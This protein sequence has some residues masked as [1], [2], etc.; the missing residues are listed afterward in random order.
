MDP[1]DTVKAVESIL[2]Q[3]DLKHNLLKNSVGLLFC[4]VDF[5]TSGMVKELSSRL[6]FEVVGCTSLGFSVPGAAEEI[7]FILMVLTSDDVEFSTGISEP[8][9]QNAEERIAELYRR[10]AGERTAKPALVFTFPPLIHNLSGNTVVD[11]LDRVSGGSPIIGGVAEDAGVAI[12]SPQTIY[13]GS[14][15]PDRLP[16]LL[17]FGDVKVRFLLDFLPGEM[18]FNQQAVITKAEGNRLI[19][20]DN[21]PAAAFM[22]KIGLIRKGMIDVL[23]AFPISVDYHDGLEPR[24]FTIYNV[25]DDGSLTSGSSIPPGGTLRIGSVTSDLVMESAVHIT[26]LIKK[27]AAREG[28]LIFSCFSRSLACEDPNAELKLVNKQLES[29]PAPY[30]FLYVSGEICPV[31]TEQKDLI[32]RF[33]QYTIVVCVLG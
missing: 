14:A 9:A 16:L 3:L 10:T 22:E 26:E 17:I 19:S 7:M 31:Y 33:H 24:V 23:Y 21:M 13:N 5:L 27:G 6:P 8:L 28:V 4:Y 25:N 1:D 15:Y 29:F 30:I 18:I 2:K 32:N 20:L 12:R 11:V